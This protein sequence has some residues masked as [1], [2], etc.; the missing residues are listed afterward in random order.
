MLIVSQSRSGGAGGLSAD[1]VTGSA[2]SVTNLISFGGGFTGK[3]SARN[4]IPNGAT[5]NTINN[6]LTGDHVAASEGMIPSY[7]YQVSGF[8]A[9]LTADQI[10]QTGNGANATVVFDT[11]VFDRLSEYDTATGVFTAGR[12]GKYLLSA[13]LK[14]N[15]TLS[16]TTC[17]VKIETS[18]RTYFLY[19]G[20]TD[21]IRS[22]SGTVT[23]NGSCIADMDRD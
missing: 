21:N 13:F 15:P 18:N 12:S 1:T 11:E 14:I 23:I 7:E 16:V 2:N 3:I 20:D 6:N 19:N 22:G 4:L 10:D 8:S 5:G 17:L 9:Q